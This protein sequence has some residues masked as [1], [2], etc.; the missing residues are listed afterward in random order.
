MLLLLPGM[1]LLCLL[2]L[3][4]G[5]QQRPAVWLLLLLVL[6]LRPVDQAVRSEDDS[7]RRR[8]R[9]RTPLVI[10]LERIILSK[11]CILREFNLMELLL[12]VHTPTFRNLLPGA[13]ACA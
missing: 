3:V 6:P 2:L 7:G 13:V 11:L 1:L 5:M 12:Y 4:M 9:L 8:R 10:W